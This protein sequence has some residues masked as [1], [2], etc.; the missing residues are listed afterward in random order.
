MIQR[1]IQI[2][3]KETCRETG[4]KIGWDTGTEMSREIGSRAERQKMSRQ[5]DSEPEESRGRFSLRDG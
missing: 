2:D 1:E 5:T 4:G 3:K